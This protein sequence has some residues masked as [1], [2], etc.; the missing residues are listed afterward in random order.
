MQR[1]VEMTWRKHVEA[2]EV[3]QRL[4]N[5]NADDRT[6]VDDVVGDRVLG[7]RIIRVLGREHAAGVH[8]R[9][10]GQP[11]REA[12]RQDFAIARGQSPLKRHEP[13][14]HDRIRR[15]HLP[16]PQPVEPEHGLGKVGVGRHGARVVGQGRI[17]L[18]V[19]EVGF[20]G[21]KGAQR[22][23]GCR[24]HVGQVRGRCLAAAPHLAQHLRRQTVGERPHSLARRG[25]GDARQCFPIAHR[26]QRHVGPHL[27]AIGH[28][29]PMQHALRAQL[30]REGARVRQWQRLRELGGAHEHAHGVHGPQRADAVEIGAQRDHEIAADARQRGVTRRTKRHDRDHVGPL[31]DRTRVRRAPPSGR[32]EGG[33]GRGRCDDV[34]QAA[35][36]G[37]R[38]TG[39]GAI[40]GDASRRAG[41]RSRPRVAPH[42]CRSRHRCHDRCP[43]RCRHA[44]Q[45]RQRFNCTLGSFRRILRHQARH[46]LRNRRR[47]VGAPILEPGHRR[48]GMGRD[49]RL[50]RAGVRW[51]PHEHLV[52]HRAGRVQVSAMVRRRLGHGLL[53]GHVRRRAE[54]HSGARQPTTGAS[55]GERLCHAEVGDDGVFSLEQDVL[56][57]HVA[58]HDP[59]FVRVAERVEH[60]AS[61]TH[62]LGERKGPFAHELHAQRFPSHERHGVPEQVAAAAGSQHRHD[63]RVLQV[64]DH[65]DLAPE[66]LGARAR[67]PFGVE[68]L[69]HDLPLQRSFAG[70]KHAC[71]AAAAEFPLDDEGTAEQG[72]QTRGEVVRHRRESYAPPPRG[73][74]VPS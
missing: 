7:E 39:C 3:G 28:D 48:R 45:H 64:R 51:R 61:D 27:R 23:V 15:Q 1:I 31:H 53:G 33:H 38:A 57:L 72:L 69:D 43:A 74:I 40:T 63:V 49:H 34:R 54:R 46:Q 18:E 36:S 8:P 24:R 13:S 56:R 37:R 70:K 9:D 26:V 11:C 5:R 50:R 32:D 12:K 52:H 62:G 6:R 30:A 44:I 35:P 47:Y 73:A 55:L 59:A 10:Q 42:L 17:H 60:L 29:R 58:V 67:G 25:G 14:A 19:L 21:Q 65:L 16:V 71:H 66:S 2:I 41:R 4:A 68:H 22:F 20:A